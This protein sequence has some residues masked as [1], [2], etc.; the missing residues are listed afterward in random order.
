MRPEPGAQAAAAGLPASRADRERVM[1]CSG[2]VGAG[3]GGQG[4]IRRA[5]WPGHRVAHLRGARSGHRRHPGRADR[6]AAAPPP[7]PGA[8][9]DPFNTAVTGGACMAGLVNVGMLAASSAGARWP[10]SC[11]VVFTIIGVI[12]AMWAMIVA[13]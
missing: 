12:V 10:W 5:D 8:A 11:F 7:V 1:T 2:H 13:S 6:S 9:P 4:R 3:P